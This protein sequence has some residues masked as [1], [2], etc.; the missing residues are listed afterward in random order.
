MLKDDDPIHLLN[1]IYVKMGLLICK[2]APFRQEIS[3][4]SVLLR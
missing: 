1:V 2:Y 4:K 3:V